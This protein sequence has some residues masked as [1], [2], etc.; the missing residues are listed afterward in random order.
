MIPITYVDTKGDDKDLLDFQIPDQ[1][2]SP[3][4][5]LLAKEEHSG[6]KSLV[7]SLIDK[8]IY[9]LRK[10]VRNKPKQLKLIQEILWYIYLSPHKLNQ[11]ETAEALKISAGSVNHYDKKIKKALNELQLKKLGL[12]EAR[13]FQAALKK[14]LEKDSSLN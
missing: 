11:T 12:A 9:Y 13:L 4:E 7:E 5:L 10:E 2:M 8:L 3:E 1:G 6:M 14:R